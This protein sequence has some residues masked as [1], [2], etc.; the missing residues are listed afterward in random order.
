MGIGIL[1][2]VIILCIIFYCK[3]KKSI[4]IQYLNNAPEIEKDLLSINLNED[5]KRINHNNILNEINSNNI[6]NM[7]KDNIKKSKTLVKKKKKKK[8]FRYTFNSHNKNEQ[9]NQN[10]NCIKKDNTKHISKINI[11]FDKDKKNYPHFENSDQ[12]ILRINQNN[13]NDKNKEEISDKKGKKEDKIDYNELTYF[14]AIKKDERNMLQ[15]FI[16]YFSHKFEII[17]IIFFPKEFSHKSLTLSLY[18]YELLLDLAFNA[19]LFSDEV[20]SQ[21]Y[22]NNGNLLFI[23]SQV[24]S[25]SSNIISCFIVYITSNLINY[26]PVLEAAKQETKNQKKFYDIFIR[27]SGFIYLKITIFYILIFISGI[28]CAYYLFIFCAIFK[29]IQKNLFMNY[30]IG[31]LWSLLYKIIASILSTI[32]RKISIRGK[33]KRLYFVSKYID[34]NI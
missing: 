1:L 34:E 32:L 29:K 12:Y 5:S 18:L 24:L 13:N 3:G 11:N 17:Q 7:A 4:K 2:I 16:S 10:I 8:V 21:K 23:T 22:Y 30:F 31:I 26:Y 33:F 9:N 28:L 15:I 20:I 27:I 19:L 25:I 14:Q 6:L